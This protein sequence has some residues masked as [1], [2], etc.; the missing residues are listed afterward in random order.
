MIT[1][2]GDHIGII[3]TCKKVYNDLIGNFLPIFVIYP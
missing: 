1:G 3:L 2:Y